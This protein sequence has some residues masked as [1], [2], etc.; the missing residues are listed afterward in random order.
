MISQYLGKDVNKSLWTGKRCE[1]IMYPMKMFTRCICQR[2]MFLFEWIEMA[3][4][5][6]TNLSF[7]S[8]MTIFIK[9][10]TGCHRGRLFND[11]VIHILSLTKY[12]HS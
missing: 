8:Y 5:V 11:L 12:V 10:V 9:T 7:P 6:V 3:R 2:R 4:S 1:D